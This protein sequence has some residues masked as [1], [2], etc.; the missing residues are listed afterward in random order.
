[1]GKLLWSCDCGLA[2]RVDADNARY[3]SGLWTRR[4]GIEGAS[5]WAHSSTQNTTENCWISLEKHI[6]ESE[7]TYWSVWPAASGP[8]PAVGWEGVRAGIDHRKYIAT[9]TKAIAKRGAAGLRDL[10]K[11]ASSSLKEMFGKIQPDG[12]P[13]GLRAGEAAGWRFGRLFHRSSPQARI[14]KGDHNRLRHRNARQTLRRRGV[15]AA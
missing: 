10:A 15:M 3:Y 1:M 5:L 2:R 14:A 9:L 6:A 7:L 13:A 11:E 12:Y 8:I 4:M